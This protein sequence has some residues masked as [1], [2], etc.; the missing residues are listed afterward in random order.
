MLDQSSPDRVE[1]HVPRDSPEISLVFHQFRA[2]TA[3]EYM[4]AESMAPSPNVGVCREEA[5]HSP[6]E[7]WFGCLQDDVEVV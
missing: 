1:M 6:G 7:I 3:L 4:P 2:V 5:L